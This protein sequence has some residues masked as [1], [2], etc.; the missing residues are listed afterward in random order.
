V[1]R[2]RPALH[3]LAARTGILEAYRDNRGRRRVASDATRVALLRALGFDAS[4]EEAARRALTDLEPRTGAALFPPVR[5]IRCGRRGTVPT[6]STALPRAHGG[7]RYE[8]EIVSEDGAGYRAEGRLPRG[9]NPRLP[10]AV[11]RQLTPGYY[12][13]RLTVRHGGVER[14]AEQLLIAAP[15]H[16]PTPLERLS[17]GRRGTRAFGVTVN[18]WT[19]RS[20]DNWGA[21]DLTDVSTLVEALG[22]AGAS[23]IG[24]NPLNALRNQGNEVSPYSPLSRLFRNPLYMDVTAAPEYRESEVARTLATSRGVEET[25]QQLRAG[26]TVQHER[27]M[28]LKWPVIEALHRAFA[29]R[30]R[31]R[32]TPRGEAYR[33]F[34]AEQG[35]PL[36]DFATFMALDRRLSDGGQNGDWHDWPAASRD[37]RGAAV[38]EFRREQAEAIDVHRYVQFE[39]DRQLGAAAERAS[40]AGLAVGLAGDLA[41]GSAPTGCDPW[42][43]PGLFV[44][45]AALGAPPDDFKSEGQDWALAPLHPLRLRASRYQYWIRLLRATLAHMGAV[46]LDHVMGLLRQYWV[47]AGRPATEG[48]YVEFPAE[49]LFAILALES[50]RRGALVIGEDLGTVPPEIPRLLRR[51]GVLST[52]VLYFERDRRGRFLPARR[53]PRRAFVT[54]HTHDQ[55]PVAG[56]WDGT[57]LELRRRAGDLPSERAF[58]R[59]SSDRRRGRAALLARLTAEHALP[60]RRAPTARDVVPAVYRFLSRTPAP[61]LGVTFDDLSGECEPVNLPGV[62]PQRFP[63]WV[64]RPRLPIEE[65]TTD[66]IAT[67]ILDAV[68][69]RSRRRS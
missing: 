31:D 4:T 16:C 7:A 49:E 39:L 64:R 40:R 28:A 54:A 22:Q 67:G 60:Q 20:R 37:P 44:E 66:P 68:A 21:G 33:R 14:H 65:V 38:R 32:D 52:S 53:Y 57:D 59:A 56:F 55:V 8:L 23:V 27:V 50:H 62:A 36:T 43:F 29:E 63:I 25:L 15:A 6:I 24:L 61:L 2:R 5:A 69:S 45:G 19:L 12:S 10:L 35:E 3:A 11:D 48:A 41:V 58:A 1:S 9:R 26:H 30:D 51:W 47:P 13:L 34:L 42:A 46:R 18:L 17:G